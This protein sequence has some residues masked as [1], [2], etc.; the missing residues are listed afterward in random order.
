MSKIKQIKEN[1]Q[2][3]TIVA[4][5]KYVGTKE[6]LKLLDEG[7][8]DFGE[9]RVD[10]FLEK[11][12]ILKD[13][14]NIT[15]HFIGTLQTN[16]VKKM[17]NSID[18]L[19]SLNSFKLAS[20]IDKYRTTP[21]KCFLEI[22]LTNSSTKTGII[23]SDVEATLDEISKLKNVTV[24]GLMTMTESDMTD[25]EKEEV[26]R[27]LSLLKTNLNNKGYDEI[28]HLSMGMSDDY[29]IALKCGATFVR[30]GRILF[31]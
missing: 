21:L 22:N 4:A 25:N 31:S 29:L 1:V 6:M 14:E 8:C 16:K 23:L 7:I 28:T 13:N 12:E 2:N 27:K 5:T 9:N 11:Y 30:L 24:I 15:W 19:H 18:Y 17:I 10:S 3:A 20:M 26:F